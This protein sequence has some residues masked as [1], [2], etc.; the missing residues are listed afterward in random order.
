[1]PRKITQRK[2]K[3][4]Y[5]QFMCLWSCVSSSDAL[6]HESWAILFCKKLLFSFCRFRFYF[7]FF[8]VCAGSTP[9]TSHGFSPARV[10]W[11]WKDSQVIHHRRAMESL[12]IILLIILMHSHPLQQS[13]R[14]YKPF[15]PYNRLAKPLREEN[16][17]SKRL[18]LHFLCSKYI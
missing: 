14:Q 12:F 4:P 15:M 11:L 2:I 5:L 9:A 3:H 13:V 16:K 10:I 17:L 18:I 1:M 8:Y 6:S 7:L